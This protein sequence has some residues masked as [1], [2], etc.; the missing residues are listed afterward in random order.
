MSQVDK[1]KTGLLN[2]IGHLPHGENRQNIQ[3]DFMN[4]GFYFPPC[5]HPSAWVCNDAELE[6]GCQ[7]M[8]GAIIQ[9]GCKIVIGS[10]IN[11]RVPIDHEGAIG[12]NVHI[13]LGKFCVAMSPLIRKL[14]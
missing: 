13:A 7:I 3:K 12:Y 5:V 10:I 6:T 9:P 14:L 2:G 8:A 1:S 4:A 11:T